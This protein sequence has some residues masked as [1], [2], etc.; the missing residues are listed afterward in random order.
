[1]PVAKIALR[2]DRAGAQVQRPTRAAA[3]LDLLGGIGPLIDER[4]AGAVLSEARADVAALEGI[5]SP[6]SPGRSAIFATGTQ[7]SQL[8]PFSEFLGY[9]ESRTGGGDLLLVS[10]GHRAMFQIGSSFGS[11]RL[12]A[13]TRLRW[14]LANHWMALL[15]VLLLGVLLLAAEL[16]RFLSRRMRERLAL[17]EAA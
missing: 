13:W 16:R 10:G 6:L 3:L 8:V 17:G 12:D 4:R 9:A 5:E 7:P 11:G 1:V 2:L 14:F 15:P